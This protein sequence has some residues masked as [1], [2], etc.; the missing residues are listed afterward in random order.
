MTNSWSTFSKSYPSLLQH[1]WSS[2]SSDYPQ[3]NPNLHHTIG[4]H[5]SKAHQYYDAETSFF[6]GPLESSKALAYLY[7]QWIKEDKPLDTHPSLNTLGY[8]MT[9]GVLGWVILKKIGGFFFGF[10]GTKELHGGWEIE[11]V[12]FFFFFLNPNPS[13]LGN[14]SFLGFPYFLVTLHWLELVMLPRC[15]K[16]LSPSFHLMN[17]REKFRLPPLLSHPIPFPFTLTPCSIGVVFC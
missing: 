4:L 3:G 14:F 12:F 2:K 6:Y 16:H 11:P 5:Y 13:Y 17:L 15:I 7:S 9:R 1:R 10:K 8:F